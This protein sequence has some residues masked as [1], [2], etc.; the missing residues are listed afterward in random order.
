MTIPMLMA[1]CLCSQV[2][3]PSGQTG[4][5]T[6][7]TELATFAG[8]YLLG[9]GITWETLKVYSGGRFSCE[10]GADDGGYHRQE[11]TAELVDGY[12]VLHPAKSESNRGIGNTALPNYRPIRWGQ[13]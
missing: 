11:G 10:W 3:K 2:P 6:S 5:R 9:D 1:A 13:R 4:D 12:L 8:E 7:Q